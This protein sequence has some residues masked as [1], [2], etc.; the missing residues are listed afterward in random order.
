MR[1]CY[2]RRAR[3]DLAAIL[4]YIEDRSP[5]GAINV[6]RALKRAIDL[7]GEHPSIGRVSGEGQTRVIP[8]GRY[9]YLIY[10]SVEA[11]EV[12]LL[13]IRHAARRQ[14]EGDR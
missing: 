10:W 3:D 6:K 2:T 11:G 12:W 14:W 7:I 13:H 1:V 5:S 8:V 4:G 9:P